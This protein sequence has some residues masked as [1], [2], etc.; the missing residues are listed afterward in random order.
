M[1][2]EYLNYITHL[3]LFNVLLKITQLDVYLM[4]KKDL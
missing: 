3:V 2:S 4:N 1:L